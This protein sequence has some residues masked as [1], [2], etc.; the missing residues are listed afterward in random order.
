MAT[1]NN[2]G[3]GEKITEFFT[4]KPA[5]HSY[6]KADGDARVPHHERTSDPKADANEFAKAAGEALPY[7][8]YQRTSSGP[9][10]PEHVD[11]R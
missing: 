10:N 3:L 2:E 11:K 8:D 5:D 7:P 1:N 4:Q 9:P 6:E